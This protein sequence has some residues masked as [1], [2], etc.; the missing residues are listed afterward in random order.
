LRKLGINIGAILVGAALVLG[1]VAVAP[2]S[3]APV[4][5]ANCTALTKVYKN[6]VAKAGVKYNRV[7]GVNR[8]LKYKP[9]YS[10][11]IYTKNLTLDRDKDGIACERS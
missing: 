7:S 11:A 5:Y 3:A 10:T 1:P 6:G 8:P 4:K 2:A 9:Y